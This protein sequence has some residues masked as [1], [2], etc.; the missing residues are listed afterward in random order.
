MVYMLDGILLNHKKNKIMP[1]AATWMELE[2]LTANEVYQKEKHKYHMISH[3]SNLIY[4]TNESFHR[5][6]THGLVEQ[7]IV[8]LGRGEGVGWTGSLGYQMQTISFGVDKQ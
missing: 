6:E 7:T 1:C 8:C 2:P 5:K 3:S 4:G